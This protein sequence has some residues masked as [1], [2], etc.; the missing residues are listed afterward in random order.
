MKA[1][2]YSE[3]GPPDVLHVKEVER[4]TPTDNEILVRV[5]A[6][7]V[8]YGDIVTRNFKNI[9]NRDFNMPSLFM[10]PTRLYFG[11]SKPKINILGSEFSGEVEEVGKDVTRFKT[12]DAVFGYLGQ[13]MGAY[14]EYLCISET[15][16]VGL[17]PAN[18]SHEE[19]ACV[20]YGG[21]MALGHLRKV[22]IREGQKVLIN[23]ASGG[24]GSVALQLLKHYG[25]EVTGVCG[26][27]RL[28]YIS[29]LGANKVIDYTK[30]DF[31]ES[32]ETYDMIYDI[33]GRSSFSRCKKSL[34]PHGRYLLAS[35]KTGKLLQMLGTSIVGKKK[36]ICAIAGEKQEDMTL[37]K[38]LAEAGSIKTI[39][40]KTYSL[41]EAAQAHQYV[42]EGQKEGQVL[43]TMN[44][45]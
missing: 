17:K 37:L 29:S 35:F 42:E 27:P 32:D 3:Y 23:G 6:T 8:N 26:T 16:M 40:D 30:E 25:A 39:I 24:I 18:M 15:G 45:T 44:H 28:D 9:R 10:L 33:L 43:I 22:T 31:T 41:E 5:K 13:K 21:I 4:L 11:L 1:V 19:A 12:G 7:P 14:A 34:T 38:E 36:V 2:V 20:A